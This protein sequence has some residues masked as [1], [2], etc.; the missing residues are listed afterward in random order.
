MG[1]ICYYFQVDTS[2]YLGGTHI[3]KWS[4]MCRGHD[5]F[6]RPVGASFTINVSLMCPPPFKFL[7]MLH[8]QPCFGQNFSSQD[9]NFPNVRS[10]DRSFF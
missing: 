1:I 5:N 8:F 3:G 10:Q 7:E 4:G 9:A 2:K 6:F